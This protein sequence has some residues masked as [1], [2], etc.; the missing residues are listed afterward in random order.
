M[1]DKCE[2]C[3]DTGWVWDGPYRIACSVCMTECS[4]CCGLGIVVYPDG[5]YDECQDCDSGFVYVRC[6]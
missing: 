6:E 3:D 4:E 1:S 5:T 2:L